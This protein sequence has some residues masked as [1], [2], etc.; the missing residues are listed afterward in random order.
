MP[1]DMPRNFKISKEDLDRILPAVKQL[2][3]EAGELAME[4][5][6]ASNFK[7]YT[8]LDNSQVTDA[9]YALHKYITSRLPGILPGVTILSEEDEE[10]PDIDINKPYWTVDPIDNTKGFIEG[11]RF[12][13][14]I[15]L[16]DDAVPVLGVIEA[17]YRDT[18]ISATWHSAPRFEDEIN[19]IDE[20]LSGKTAPGD[21]TPSIL[22]YEKYNLSTPFKNA[23]AKLELHGLNIDPSPHNTVFSNDLPI[24]TQVAQGRADIYIN[25]GAK[26]TLDSGNGYSWDYAPN[27]LFLRNAGGALI[28]INSG[29][30]VIFDKPTE[31]M[32]G[33]AGF[34]NR[35][36]ARHYFPGL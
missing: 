13:V 11:D 25:H 20:H 17:P 2:A 35:N 15:A 3:K 9:D 12:Y 24:F 14:N 19:G 32:N 29:K 23:A 30:E 26:D 36:Y 5:R 8:K 6:R 33:M 18:R 7:I 31:Q 27:W 10:H 21:H 28:E 22:G 1:L 4:F 34:A 16:I